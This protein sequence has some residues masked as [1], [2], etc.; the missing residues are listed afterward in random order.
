PQ[1][2]KLCH[3]DASFVAGATGSVYP[4]AG[5]AKMLAKVALRAHRHYYALVKGRL[6]AGL[7]YVVNIHPVTLGQK[8]HGKTMP[9]H[10]SAFSARAGY[11]PIVVRFG[12]AQNILHRASD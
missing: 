4:S 8:Q 11:Q 7:V 1:C 6:Y 3:G 5:V 12:D 10:A 2:L 9:V